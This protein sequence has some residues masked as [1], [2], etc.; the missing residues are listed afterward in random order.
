M[1]VPNQQQ[2]LSSQS[3]SVKQRP[4][5][6]A[7]PTISYTPTDITIPP[8]LYDKV[9]DLDLYKKLKEA[10]KKLDLLKTRKALD[11]QAINAKL[12]QTT[13]AKK[14]TGILRVFVYNTCENQPWQKLTMRS[15]VNAPRE[16][17]EEA[18]TEATWTLRVEGRFIGGGLSEEKQNMKFS[19]FLSGISVELESYGDTSHDKS[20]IIEWKDESMNQQFDNKYSSGVRQSVFDGLDVKRTGVDNVPTKIAILVKD[21]SSKL[22][23]SDDMARFV[24]RNEATQQELIYT[25]WQY[26]LFKNL[27]KKQDFLDIPAVTASGSLENSG[28]GG[29]S[30]NGN[31]SDDFSIVECDAILQDLLKVESF[32][33][34]DLYKIL[35]SHFKPK[36]PIILDYE[37]N[38]KVSNTLGNLIVDIPV[39]LPLSLSHTQKKIIE[40]TKSTYENLTKVDA[41][42]QNLNN[43]I[44]LGIVALQN[45]NSRESFYRELS[46]DPVPFINRWLETQLETFKILKSDEGYDEELVRR[47][48]FFEE[49]EDLLKQKI[50]VLLG[51]NRL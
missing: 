46:E 36:E 21:H 34:S 4:N 12:S 14:D 15:E 37:V 35:Q 50:D 19:S 30:I 2:G 38:T 11:F 43:R 49:N 27:L 1:I 8:T 41:A 26:V 45:A 9:K 24:G 20:N 47:A 33:F 29:K 44:S 5:P 10:E 16:P 31:S 51:S 42:V 17:S 23:L 39:D 32:K 13:S 6:S 28:Q 25:I 3:G 18:S 40:D 7:T 22:R 48:K